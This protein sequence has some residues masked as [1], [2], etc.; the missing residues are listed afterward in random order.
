MEQLSLGVEEFWGKRH[1]QHFENGFAENCV[2][3]HSRHAYAV[4][5]YINP[6]GTRGQRES[7]CLPRYSRQRE[8]MAGQRQEDFEGVLE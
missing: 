8:P 2:G 4:F 1:I 5:I 6:S 7:S 3:S